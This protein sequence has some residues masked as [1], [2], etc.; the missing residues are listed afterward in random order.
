[1][2]K[3]PKLAVVVWG[4]THHNRGRMLVDALVTGF[5]NCRRSR[6]PDALPAVCVIAADTCTGSVRFVRD[7]YG[8]AASQQQQQQHS[9]LELM[10][11]TQQHI[12]ISSSLNPSSSSSVAAAATAMESDSARCHSIRVLSSAVLRACAWFTRVTR[13][14]DVECGAQASG[15]SGAGGGGANGSPSH[16]IVVVDVSTS[17]SDEGSTESATMSSGLQEPTLSAF[18]SDVAFAAAMRSVTLDR[19]AV[20][21]SRV[22][23]HAACCHRGSP[24]SRASAQLKS[25]VFASGGRVW[26]VSNDKVM[27]RD[28]S[29]TQSNGGCR[30]ASSILRHMLL[31]SLLMDDSSQQQQLARHRLARQQS[32]IHMSCMVQ[33]AATKPASGS[34]RGREDGV[35]SASASG[36]ASFGASAYAICAQ[37]MSVQE[38]L[39]DGLGTSATTQQAA[40]RNQCQ[41]CY[42]ILRSS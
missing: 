12:A 38:C 30:T 16:S 20:G 33:P 1:M 10:A 22:V 5:V 36:S 35:D 29:T 6:S 9:S 31:S 7:S 34:K 11:V 42:V 23:V 13:H 32:M 18:G 17:G 24:T 26:D 21:G 41:L 25:M 19:A 14:L 39:D 4:D 8:G 28:G 3:Y 40:G 2:S 15:G 27:E 37:C